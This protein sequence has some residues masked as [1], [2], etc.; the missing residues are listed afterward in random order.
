MMVQTTNETIKVC[1][2]MPIDMSEEAQQRA[3]EENPENAKIGLNFIEKFADMVE[4]SRMALIA[5]KKWNPG[6]TLRVRFLSGDPVVHQKI[7]AVAHQWSQYTNIKFQFGNDP[8]AEIRISCQMGAG[9]WSYM[10]TDALS[11]AKDQPTMNYG[12]LEPNTGDDEY[13]RVVLHEFGHALGCIHEHQH[14]EAGIPWNTDAVYRYYMGPPNN[15]S[16]DEVDSQLFA[17]YGK[18]ITQFSQYDT[19]SIMH[20]PVPKELTTGNFEIGWNRVLSETDKAFIGQMYPLPSLNGVFQIQSKHSGKCLDLNTGEGA[21]AANGTILWQWDCNGGD[22]QKWLVTPLDDGSY[23]IKSKYS[24]KCFDLNFGEE[25]R[26]ANGTA[27]WQW[28]WHGNDNQRWFLIP[29]DDGSYQIQSKY[30]GKCF[31]LSLTDGSGTANGTNILQ[32]DWHGGNNQR[33]I[34]TPSS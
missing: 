6:R 19:N 1:I 23:Q 5:G 7:E 9:S 15:W 31:D 18:D 2:D 24:G 8:D 29:L 11:I 30:S 20:Y 34:L 21:G 4:F 27:I 26:N 12:W 13:S 10:G 32:W 16:K 22:N 25:A 33:W 17:R 28:D 3:V 14:P